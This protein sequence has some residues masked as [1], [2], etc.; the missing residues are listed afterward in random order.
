[1]NGGA[2]VELRDVG[3]ELEGA[4]VLSGVSVRLD[5]PRIAV[6]GENGS[7][8]STFARLLAGLVPAARGRV[9]V[10][11]LDPQRDGRRLRC[12]TGFV[13]GNPDAQIVMPTVAEDLAFSLR[14]TR[15]SRA[16]RERLVREALAEAGLEGMGHR[17]VYTLSGGQK[18]MLALAAATIRRPRLL[19]ADEPTA[20]LD[21]RNAR[22]VAARL[23]DGPPERRLVLVTHDLALAAR[24]DEAIRFASGRLVD[25]GPPEDVAAG[26]ERSLR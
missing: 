2:G 5:A 18:Q 10:L 25:H 7:G 23:L 20:A 9:R 6:I 12:L 24:C 15:H 16:E 8:K 11:G 17:P 14:G 1:M 19:V 21:A 4:T 3:V 26:Y 22:A 13:F